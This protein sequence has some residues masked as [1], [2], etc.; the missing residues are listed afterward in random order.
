MSKSITIPFY[1]IKLHLSTG[2]ELTMPLMDSASLQIGESITKLTEK[3]NDAFQKKIM[4]EGEYLQLMNE[5]RSGDFSKDSVSVLFPKAKDGMR[6]PAFTI[7]FQYLYQPI[8]A[9]FWGVVPTLGVEA[10]SVDLADLKAHI[11]EAIQLEF[12]RNRRL[13]AVHSIVSAIWYENIDL[14]QKQIDLTILSPN[15]QEDVVEQEKKAWL[16][17]VAEKLDIRRQVMFGREAELQQLSQILKSNFGRNVLL[18]GPSGVGKTVLVWE[19][20]RRK[21]ELGIE[22]NIW[23]TTASVLI[24]E[25]TQNTGWQDNLVFLCKEL[26]KTGDILFVRSLA[27]LFEVGRYEGNAVSMAEYLRPFISRGEI[28]LLSECTDGELAHIEAQNPNYASFFQIIRLEEPRE[29][30]EKIILAKVQDVAKTRSIK[31]ENKAISEVIRLNRRFTPYAGFPGKPI[32]FLESIIINQSPDTSAD[33]KNKK[34]KKNKPPA[35]PLQIID[36]EE[37]IQYFCEES[38]MPPFMVDATIPMDT[39]AIKASF[40]NQVFGQFKAVNGVV[41][42][43]AAVKTAMTRT[44]Q[45]IASFLFVGPTGVGKTEL[46]KV[47]ANFMFGR[48]DRMIRFDMS[49]YANPYSVLRLTGLGNSNGLLTSAVRREPFSVLL[50]DEIEKADASFYDLLL[51]ILSEGRLTDDQG[52]LV[53]FCS[54]IIIMTSNIGAANLQSNRIGW[55]KGLDAADVS[56][57]FKS[58]VEKHFRPEFFNRIDQ[59]IPFDPL[60]EDTIRFVVE[61]EIELFKKL[62]GIQFRNLD[63]DIQEEVLDLLGKKG[64]DPKYGARQLQRTIREELMTPL[65]KALNIYDFDD[66]VKVVIRVE[67]ETIKVDLEEDIFGDDLLMEQW[68]KINFSEKASELRRKIFKLQEGHFYVRLLSKLDILEQEKKR[69]KEEFWKNNARA[70]EYTYYLETKMK[71]RDLTEKIEDYERTLSLACMDLAVYTTNFEE[72]LKAWEEAFFNLKTEIYSRLH[73]THHTAYLSIYGMNF[74]QI[75]DFYVQL[76]LKKDYSVSGKTVWYREKYY[77]EEIIEG[78]LATDE[79]NQEIIVKK[80][81][82]Y[83]KKEWTPTLK[84]PYPPEDA[85]DTLVGIE[86]EIK[87]NCA[88]VFFQHEAGIQQW[89]VLNERPRFFEVTVKNTRKKTPLNIFRKKYFQEKIPRRFVDLA[90]VRDTKLR[91]ADPIPKEG[92]VTWFYQILE[93]TFQKD[94]NEKVI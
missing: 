92:L 94:I 84:M 36:K 12:T 65:A 66:R 78:V 54:A 75:L 57:H 56:A 15:E 43:L 9:G 67:N 19:L 50:F 2:G 24:K 16:P 42:I 73:P 87:G 4:N 34:N 10:F 44:G 88:Y 59:I 26:A 49:E 77:N 21:A 82:A 47:L 13:T 52:K 41:N 3:Y 64:Y 63:L 30:L 38:G 79:N 22:A 39:E 23:E 81:E 51:Q 35:L 11:A 71:V 90:M 18:V 58:A 93:A 14:V 69:L 76:S 89:E 70:D 83:I 37:V 53:N 28:T 85:E 25:L 7:E 80:R 29:D 8:Q 46:A 62:E 45:P 1:A 91:L 60:D 86:L 40:N 32:R 74:E 31:I 68:S 6:F 27:E 72:H 5:Y 61:R 55:K 17:Q 33:T 20:A 48:R